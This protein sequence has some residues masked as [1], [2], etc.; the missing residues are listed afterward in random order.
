MA[1]EIGP[2]EQNLVIK[3]GGGVHT[4]AAENDVKD[5]EASSGQNFCLDFQNSQL[6]NRPSFDLI[7]TAPNA[8]PINGFVSLLKTDGTVKMAV[9]AGNTVYDFNGTAFGSTLDTV[10]SSARL[11]GQ[12]WANWPLDD[13]VIISDLAKLEPLKEW[14]GSTW[15]D[16]THNLTGTFISKYAYVEN[17]RLWLAN[18]IS[19]GT[20]TPH[21][22][23]GSERSDYT[24][25]SVSTRPAS[26]LGEA[27]AVFMISPDNRP[28]NGLVAAFE[29]VVISGEQGNISILTGGSSKDF[30]FKTLHPRSGA[31]GD[32][33]L[34]YIGN[35]IVYGRPGIIE[36]LVATER[37]G[38]V[39]NADLSVDIQPT[40]AGYKDW[41]IVYNSRLQRAYCIPAGQSEIWV[42]HKDMAGSGVSP[43]SKWVTA[44]ASS[45][46]PT[47]IMSCLDPVD[48]LEYVYFGDSSGNLYKLEGS[49]A[50]DGGTA[51]IKTEFLSRLYEISLDADAYDIEGWVKYRQDVANYVTMSFEFSGA[52]IFQ[53]EITVDLPDIQNRRVYGGSVYYGDDEYYGNTF[54][55]KLVRKPFLVAGH[56][57]EFQVR[58]T[59]DGQANFEINQIGL[60]F[61]AA[62]A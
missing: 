19:N 52:L 13:K 46:Q 53:Q 16:V 7:A 31:D 15:A 27:D 42:Y 45:F 24:T 56:S 60:R 10:N 61:R 3:F 58:V 5:Q 8:A 44:H 2:A 39:S 57:K 41:T 33:T 36:S 21:I 40:L 35:D 37:F 23:V 32:E 51:N 9:Q 43:W 29:N 62:T 49:A 38:D 6:R 50:A 22:I 25:L 47:A 28:I 48:G 4:R 12:L 17:E 30:A 20:D 59:V 18:V 11:R 55:G 54:K 34:S 14:D 26:G 1:T